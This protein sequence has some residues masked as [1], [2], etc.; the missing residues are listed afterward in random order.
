MQS[1]DRSQRP[2]PVGDQHPVQ[3]KRK[4]KIKDMLEDPFQLDLN[5]A[6]KADEERENLIR[7]LETKMT[8]QV[9]PPPVQESDAFK[10]AQETLDLLNRKLESAKAKISGVRNKQKP[11]SVFAEGDLVKES[12]QIQ[13]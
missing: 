6:V 1:G 13:D 5:S 4:I 11:V 10:S 2:K 12:T 7:T 3:P 8:H 9:E